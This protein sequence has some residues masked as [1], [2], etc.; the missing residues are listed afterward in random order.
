MKTQKKELIEFKLVASLRSQYVTAGATYC[1]RVAVWQQN[2]TPE[3]K[4]QGQTT[5]TLLPIK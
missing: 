4:E 5:A 3:K 2:E 1:Q